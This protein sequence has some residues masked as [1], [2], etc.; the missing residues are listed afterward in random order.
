MYISSKCFEI[1]QAPQL[2]NNS[3]AATLDGNTD[4]KIPYG[5]HYYPRLVYFYPIFEKH[6][7]V[8]KEIFSENS[9]LMHGQYSR[10]VSNQ[11][12]VMMA[13]IQYMNIWTS[14]SNGTGFSCPGGQ[15]DRG[16]NPSTGRDGMG[17]GVGGCPILFRN[18]AS[19]T[20]CHVMILHL[21]IF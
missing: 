1:A 6:F 12:Q 10:A 4:Y 7:L 9:V 20:A 15:R 17:Q 8:F 14:V 11:E 19:Y 21:L 3:G 2:K 18:T 13:R 5:R 16:H